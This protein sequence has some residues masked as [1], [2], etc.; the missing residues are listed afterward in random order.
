MNS[1]LVSPDQWRG[2]PITKVE[3]HKNF[4]F[5]GFYFFFP[6]SWFTVFCPFSTVQ[7]GDTVTHTYVHFLPHITTSCSIVAD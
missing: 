2:V 6:Y 7:Q 4:H 5:N 1:H 3:P